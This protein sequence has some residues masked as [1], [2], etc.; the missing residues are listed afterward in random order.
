MQG[1]IRDKPPSDSENAGITD[2][3]AI[4]PCVPQQAQIGVQSFQVGVVGKDVDRDI[5]L[6]PSIMGIFDRLLY[7]FLVEI[8]GPG[9]KAEL[10]ATEVDGVGAIVNGGYQFFETSG[11]GQ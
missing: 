1:Q 3:E 4:G 9:A 10:F 8:G 6:D 5:D 11:R 2:N 7:P